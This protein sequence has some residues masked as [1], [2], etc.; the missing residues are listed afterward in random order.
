MSGKPADDG[1]EQVPGWLEEA[2][3][4][5]LIQDA[6]RHMTAA[7]SAAIAAERAQEQAKEQ[8]GGRP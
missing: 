7:E 3:H 8:R 6:H 4:D 2:A 1:Q 5:E